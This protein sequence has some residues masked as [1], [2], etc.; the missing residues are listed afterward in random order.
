ML[1]Y[2]LMIILEQVFCCQAEIIPVSFCMLIK[3][4]FNERKDHHWPDS[5][6]AK[7]FELR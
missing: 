2:S 1:K 6:R 7:F 4:I 3:I 5:N